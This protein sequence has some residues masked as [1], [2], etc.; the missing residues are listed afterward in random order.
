MCS[1]TFRRWKNFKEEEIVAAG[2]TNRVMPAFITD[3]DEKL[4]NCTDPTVKDACLLACVQA[5]NHY[6]ISAYGTA[7]AFANALELENH[8]AFFREAAVNEKHI[9]DRLSQLAEHEINTNAKMPGAL[10]Q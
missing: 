1:S 6:K 9:D 7:A 4:D 5:I 8:A 2:L 3:A 10:H